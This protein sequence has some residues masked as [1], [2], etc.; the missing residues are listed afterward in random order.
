MP[1]FIALMTGLLLILVSGC[2]VP[3]SW[4]QTPEP[5]VSK[6]ATPRPGV[7]PNLTG[8][9]VF[10]A[11]QAAESADIRLKLGFLAPRTSEADWQVWAMARVVC[12]QDVAPGSSNVNTIEIEYSKNCVDWKIVPD[13]VGLPFYEGFKLAQERGTYIDL[14]FG[15]VPEADDLRVVCEQSIEAGVERPD[16][17][18]EITLSKNCDAYLAEK[19]ATQQEQ[20]ADDDADAERRALLNDPDTREGARVFINRAFQ[21]LEGLDDNLYAIKLTAQADD[22]CLL[23][24]WVNLVGNERSAT[25]LVAPTKYQERWLSLSLDLSESLE[26]LDVARDDYF[27]RIINSSELVAYIDKSQSVRKKMRVLVSSIPYPE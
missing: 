15:G 9:K 1:R 10:G 7:A 27:D 21:A 2:T 18:I 8:M 24:C 26:E 12:T 20:E 16:D 4:I 5:S 17:Q 19:L 14:P 3:A 22:V 23:W 6:S 13:L 11:Q 25:S